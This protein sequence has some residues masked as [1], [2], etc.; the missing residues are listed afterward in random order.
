MNRPK[1]IVRTAR[2]RRHCRTSV[3]LLVTLAHRATCVRSAAAA[4][5]AAKAV[6]LSYRTAPSSSTTTSTAT[7]TNT[8]TTDAPPPPTVE[9]ITPLLD[10]ESALAARALYP[11]AALMPWLPAGK[12]LAPGPMTLA[13]FN[14]DVDALLA[15][16]GAPPAAA[17]AGLPPPPPPAAE[18]PADGGSSSGEAAA[19]TANGSSSS[20]SG[21]ANGSSRERKLRVVRG[22]YY[23]P[24]QLHVYMETQ[25]AVA[26]PEEDG[27]MTVQSA[28]Q[29]TDV[30]QV[31][32]DLDV[33]QH[34]KGKR[35]EGKKRLP[36]PRAVGSILC[37][38]VGTL[39]LVRHA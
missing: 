21:D 23:T 8:T 26:A 37:V 20:S 35:E 33:R 29:G 28:C 10:I 34:G 12:S 22:R 4:H 1:P 5:R 32:F 18:P 30:I 6:Q 19:A 9:P 16:A 25:S 27:G 2:F 24:S 17:A 3:Y 36:T 31:G 38:C 14:G 11:L 39:W 7:A 13:P 15:A